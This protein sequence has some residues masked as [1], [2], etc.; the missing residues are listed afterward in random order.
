MSIIKLKEIKSLDYESI[1][2]NYSCNALKTWAREECQ[3][4]MV[5]RFTDP[6]SEE[7]V[8]EL[9]AILKPSDLS[10][11]IRFLMSVETSKATNRYDVTTHI[12][13]RAPYYSIG[14]FPAPSSAMK[15][16]GGPAKESIESPNV[17]KLPEKISASVSNVSVAPKALAPI[18]DA[19][20]G[21]VYYD[22]EIKDSVKLGTVGGV[23][24]RPNAL[25]SMVRTLVCGMRNKKEE[26]TASGL[27]LRNDLSPHLLVATLGADVT[28]IATDYDQTK[29]DLERETLKMKDV[30]ARIEAY[31]EAAPVINK[32][33][34]ITAKR[35][36]ELR[37]LEHHF[38][39]HSYARIECDYTGASNFIDTY[40][41]GG[42]SGNLA[43][44]R[45]NGY[46]GIPGTH[47]FEHIITLFD[48]GVV[49]G[50]TVLVPSKS[51]TFIATLRAVF[52]PGVYGVGIGSGMMSSSAARRSV[53][54]WIYVDNPIPYASSSTTISGSSAAFFS[55]LEN[56]LTLISGARGRKIMM[57]P[58][59]ALFSSEIARYLGIDVEPFLEAKKAD[60]LK[61]TY[62]LLD[63]PG[64]R[65][66]SF[67]HKTLTHYK[68]YEGNYEDIKI[69]D[70]KDPSYYIPSG[71]DAEELTY[72]FLKD[73]DVCGVLSVNSMIGYFVFVEKGPKIN[74][75]EAI[76]QVR[77]CCK[78]SYGYVWTGQPFCQNFYDIKRLAKMESGIN[79]VMDDSYSPFFGSLTLEDIFP[80]LDTHPSAHVSNLEEKPEKPNSEDDGAGL[81]Y[82]LRDFED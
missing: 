32:K 1:F 50:D 67:P 68:S 46:L 56:R 66:V 57:I 82:D 61:S 79:M 31:R 9:A 69:P 23:V 71:T 29:L 14:T 65:E 27:H 16:I 52:G 25:Q 81:D 13:E 17:E 34:M 55:A 36:G 4:P 44:E 12:P 20:R 74:A 7:K 15:L 45:K 40:A 53:F 39:V 26:T 30:G 8:R 75:I 5:K 60:R 73:K 51:S 59:V 21:V 19:E 63:K 76:S 49:P 11:V 70:H 47:F 42:T 72:N 2:Q 64:A 54:K 10:R 62:P 58:P 28:K 38:L 24:G 41:Q 22:P 35:N 78:L 3:F 48:A 80:V 33:A 18:V 43:K 37:R 6:V 77:G